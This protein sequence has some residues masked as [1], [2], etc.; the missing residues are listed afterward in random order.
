[1]TFLWVR[2]VNGSEVSGWNECPGGRWNLNSIVK[3][4]DLFLCSVDEERERETRSR[5]N[6]LDI[7]TRLIELASGHASWEEVHVDIPEVE[8]QL[9]HV[10]LGPRG[11]RYG[12]SSG[13][14]ASAAGTTVPASDDLPSPFCDLA[15]GVLEKDIVVHHGTPAIAAHGDIGCTVAHACALGAR[16]VCDRATQRAR[17]GRTA[18]TGVSGRTGA[19]ERTEHWRVCLCKGCSVWDLF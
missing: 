2:R 14:T 8:L 4:T 13:C 9:E 7:P 11:G 1:M 6:E 16:L 12:T 10:P 15:S 18:R 3:R 17:R 5:R 19:A